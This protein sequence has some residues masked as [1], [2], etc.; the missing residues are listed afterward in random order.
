MNTGIVVVELKEEAE[1]LEDTVNPEHEETDNS[2][3]VT[4][5]TEASEIV[6]DMS[7][8]PQKKITKKN[9]DKT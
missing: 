1:G 6:S 3:T 9:D 2:V 7:L 5:D 4:P 8:K